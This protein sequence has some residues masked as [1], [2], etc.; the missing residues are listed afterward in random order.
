MTSTDAHVQALGLARTAV[1]SRLEAIT[2]PD[3]EKVTPCSEWNLRELVN[4]VVGL[5]HR[6]AR[7]VCAGSV[8]EYVTTRDDDWIGGD[9]LAAWHDGVRAL[10]AA[11]DAA[12]SLDF[13]VAYRVP[14]SARDVIGLAGF[15]TAIHTWD[16][17]RAIGFDEQ[18]DEGLVEFALGYMNRLREDARL[19]TYFPEPAA[20]LPAG[21]SSQI[22]LLHLAGRTP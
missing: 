22:L 18:L 20:K 1:L 6:I 19:A 12:H 7:L 2:A 10:D 9:H 16:V 5:Q 14:M 8:E 21:A 4:H 13:T 3:W 15:D 11:I 17:S